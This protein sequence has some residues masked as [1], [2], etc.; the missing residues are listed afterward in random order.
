MLLLG[1]AKLIRVPA[2]ISEKIAHSTTKAVLI[3]DQPYKIILSNIYF[4][5][6]IKNK[7]IDF[8]L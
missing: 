3:T 1:R 2:R 4:Q 7:I 5:I 8:E 6:L